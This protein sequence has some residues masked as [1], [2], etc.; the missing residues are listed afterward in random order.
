MVKIEISDYRVGD[1]ASCGLDRG[2]SG[3]WAQV[4]YGEVKY[5]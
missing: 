5:G 1:L 4:S 2:A 3:Y